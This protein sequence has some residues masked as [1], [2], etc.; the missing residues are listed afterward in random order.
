MKN[1]TSGSAAARSMPA[2]CQ[3]RR[4]PVGVARYPAWTGRPRRVATASSEPVL[5]AQPDRLD[6]GCVRRRQP[7]TEHTSLCDALIDDRDEFEISV[8][9]GHD[10]V[11]RPPVRMRS[12]RVAVGRRRSASDRGGGR[13]PL[14]RPGGTARPGGECGVDQP[15]SSTMRVLAALRPALLRDPDVLGV[16]RGVA[17]GRVAH[18]YRGGG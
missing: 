13:S 5:T 14:H 10:P 6:D 2:S 11:R 18:E 7:A 8:I 12:S 3:V 15:A 9:D 17:T 4:S 1:G 16:G